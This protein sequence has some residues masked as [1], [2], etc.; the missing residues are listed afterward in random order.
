MDVKL[1]KLDSL[2]RLFHVSTGEFIPHALQKSHRLS[3]LDQI[4]NDGIEL[5]RC[6]RMPMPPA[7]TVAFRKPTRVKSIWLHAPQK[8]IVLGEEEKAL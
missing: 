3:Q 2:S 7:G 1:M 4:D 6:E 5:T 8:M